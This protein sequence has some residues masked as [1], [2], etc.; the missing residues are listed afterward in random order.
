MHFNGKLT[1][2]GVETAG[3]ME[4]RASAWPG[5]VRVV[6]YSGTSGCDRGGCEG[7]CN[8]GETTTRSLRGARTDGERWGMENHSHP[9]EV[10]E[11][12][13]SNRCQDCDAEI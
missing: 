9:G 11:I 2:T 4:P 6:A 10:S 8:L 3:Q 1:T 7:N 13:V 12:V 5:A